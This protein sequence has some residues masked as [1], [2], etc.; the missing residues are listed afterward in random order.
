MT[1]PRRM[2]D[3]P[4]S[5]PRSKDAAPRP[6]TF[7]YFIGAIIEIAA[8]A[9]VLVRIRSRFS[10]AIGL[11]LI[12]LGVHALLRYRRSHKRSS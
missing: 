7:G 5:P 11:F 10:S 3:N 9:V 1:Q 6:Q 4:Y 8:G 12:F 2:P